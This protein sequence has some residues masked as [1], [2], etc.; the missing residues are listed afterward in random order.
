MGQSEEAI[1]QMV[2]QAPAVI[3]AQ[4]KVSLLDL[5]LE[6]MRKIT[7][8][9]DAPQMMRLV[10]RHK[11]LLEELNKLE[12]QVRSQ[13]ARGSVCWIRQFGVFDFT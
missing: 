10:S 6:Q 4:K 13:L 2:Q 7:A 5:Q 8:T 12:S 1:E 9:P 3:E 11:L